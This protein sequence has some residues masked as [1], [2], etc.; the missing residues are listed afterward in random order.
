VLWLTPQSTTRYRFIEL[1]DA[2]DDA[3]FAACLALHNW[4]SKRAA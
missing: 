4:R 3:A 1:K 2:D